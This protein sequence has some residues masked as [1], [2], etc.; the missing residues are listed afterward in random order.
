MK[1][2]LK[3]L[4]SPVAS[5]KD[6]DKAEWKKKPWLLWEIFLSLVKVDGFLV[7]IVENRIKPEKRREKK[8]EKREWR[9]I[10]RNI[11]NQQ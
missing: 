11:S 4:S 6:Q 7:D 9:E 5:W 8:R 1:K 10:G 3:E 2:K